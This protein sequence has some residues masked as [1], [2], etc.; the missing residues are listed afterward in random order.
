MHVEGSIGLCMHVTAH[1][2]HLG[3]SQHEYYLLDRPT[4][5]NT[6]FQP[7]TILSSITTKCRHE[8]LQTR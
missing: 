3:Y 5:D 8:L 6:Y 4:I 1:D 7:I 2:Y